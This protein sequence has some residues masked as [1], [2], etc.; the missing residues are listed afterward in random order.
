M[1]SKRPKTLGGGRYELL[2][3]VGTG[4]VATVFRARDHHRDLDCAI[5]LLLPS[6]ARSPKT[7][8]RFLT[9]A[10]TMVDLDH[11]NVI[12]VTD[13]GE[14]GGPFYFAMELARGGSLSDMLRA[15]GARGPREALAL[16]FQVLQGLGHAHAHGVI[17][18][19]IKPQNML[20]SKPLEHGPDAL[21]GPRV[22]R[23]RVKLTDFGIAKRTATLRGLHITGTD[24]TLG[25]LAYMS[26]EQR[27]D[28]REAGPRSD[29]Y[30]VGATLYLL[31][32]GRRPFDL[33]VSSDP[34]AVLERLPQPL[35][36]LL[37]T[38]TAQDPAAR[39]PTTQVMANAVASAYNDLD[40]SASD[41]LE[42]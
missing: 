2:E 40:P 24:D 25:T 38:A 10:S 14:E 18:R 1:S 30:G 9:E 21:A 34:D 20:L 41:H 26:P 35:R 19:D 28:P 27:H 32:T 23:I 33:A 22:R 29:L 42:S 7:R 4:G 3:P 6:A 11:P 37:R 13:V 16:M 15:H 8:H 17:H 39:Y 5:K 36:S 31:V 12:R